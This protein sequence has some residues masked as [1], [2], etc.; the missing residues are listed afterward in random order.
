MKLKKNIAISESGFLFNPSSGDSFSSN[1]IGGEILQLLKNGKSIPEI[2]ALLI[3]KYEV[4]KSNLSKDIDDFMSQLRENN[5][6]DV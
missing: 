1:P 6:L 5:I 2:E 4:E 3:E